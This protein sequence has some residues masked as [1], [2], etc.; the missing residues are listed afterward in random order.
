MNLGGPVWQ[1]CATPKPGMPLNE[2]LALALRGWARAALEG[3][4]DASLGEWETWTG[5]A[6]HPWT[7]LGYALRRRLSV[8]EQDSVGPALDVRGTPE[9]E[10]RLA[11]V[12]QWL[13][14]GW[15]E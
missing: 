12:A 7:G 14:P 13:P 3:V 8:V 4:G 1:A 2:P 9:A 6:V 15:K 10:R 5:R 11:V